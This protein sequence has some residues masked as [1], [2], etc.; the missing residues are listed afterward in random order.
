MKKR[1]L[2]VRDYMSD[3]L[4]TLDSETDILQ[5]AHILIKN[6]LSGAPVV[7]NSGK[8]VGILTERDVLALAVQAYYHGTLGGIAKDHMTAEPQS[9]GPDASLLDVAQLFIKGRFH[10]FPVVDDGRLIGVISRSDVM[11]ALGEYYPL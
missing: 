11:R 1:S 3:N 9:V 2:Q 6:Q 5:A 10:R 7:D 8:L 4:I